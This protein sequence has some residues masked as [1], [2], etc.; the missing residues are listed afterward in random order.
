MFKVFIFTKLLIATFFVAVVIGGVSSV[1]MGA[2]LNEIWQ[3][4][5]KLPSQI[6]SY[7]F[8]GKFDAKE[9]DPKRKPVTHLGKF[10]QS[11]SNF[12]VESE[13]VIPHGMVVDPLVKGA[14]Y[15]YNGSKFQ[16]FMPGREALSFS[17]QSQHPGLY[18]LPNP[19]MLPYSW[20]AASKTNFS[21]IKDK[22]LWSSRFK[23]AQ[24]D[25]SRTVNGIACELV[26]LPK[27]ENQD[28]AYVYFAKDLGYY[29]MKTKIIHGTSFMTVEVT[30]HT[31]LNTDDGV[32]VFPLSIVTKQV[33][34]K[35]K[36]MVSV[37]WTILAPS[38]KINHRLDD[39][40][41]TISPAVAKTVT[42]YDKE[43]Q[44]RGVSDDVVPQSQGENKML[45]V[46]IIAGILLI[47]IAISTKAYKRFQRKN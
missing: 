8:E 7:Q 26:I 5:S 6:S 31:T 14:V 4:A 38:I 44:K 18:W 40:L 41:F 47:L 2:N 37:E 34:D 11:G 22:K 39:D 27:E 42:D 29:P 17:N 16:W 10:W 1:C 45:Y 30:Q 21:D 15:A 36:E 46:L 28:K 32:V 33:D 35:G 25:G 9:G 3:E 20:L 13:L 12:R 24:H 43:L 19:V 23:E